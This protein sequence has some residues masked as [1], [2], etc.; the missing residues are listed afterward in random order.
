MILANQTPQ[1]FAVQKRQLPA[2]VI[3]QGLGICFFFW[4]SCYCSFAQN[5]QTQS[6]FTIPDSITSQLETFRSPTAQVDF[7]LKTIEQINGKDKRLAYALALKTQQLTEVNDLSLA[8]AQ[9]AYWEVATSYEKDVWNYKLKQPQEELAGLYEFFDEKNRLFWKARCLALLAT[10]QY[11]RGQYDDAQNSIAILMKL[12]ASFKDQ[13]PYAEILGD[14]YRIQANLFYG[15]KHTDSIAYYYQKAFDQYALDAG[16]NRSKMALININRAISATSQGKFDTSSNYYREAA[17]LANKDSNLQ[18]EIYLEWGINLAKQATKNKDLQKWT[19]SNA[20]LY[21]SD[22]LSPLFKPR[23]YYQLGANHQNVALNTPEIDSES[24]DTLINKALSYYIQALQASVD[25]ANQNI[26]SNV[27][28]SLVQLL[29]MGNIREDKKVMASINQGYLD[30]YESLQD[31][32]EVLRES[33]REKSE[34]EIQKVRQSRTRL[35]LIL[36]SV[37]IALAGISLFVYQQQRIKNLKQQFD[38]RMEA[39]RSQMNSHFIANTLNAIDS[40]IMEGR[41]EE[42]SKYIVGFSRLCRNILNS[43]KQ[44]YIKLSEEVQILEDYLTFEKLRLGNRLQVDWQIDETLDLKAHKVP[45]LILQPF[46]ENAIWHGILNKPNRLPG[47]LR[48]VLSSEG[49]E[50]LKCLIED[51]GIGRD[52]AKALRNQQAIEWQSWGMKITSERIQAIQQIK[53]A[54]VEIVDLFDE[55]GISKGTKVIILLPKHLKAV[56]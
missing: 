33:Q 53:D 35:A 12:A 15:T 54:K 6:A 4:I 22:T 52:K 27:S 26:L 50:N 44:A 14:G 32:E 23:V 45:S 41:K 37:L 39:L 7:L 2:L 34:M 38:N 46:V 25:N 43:S 30:I 18:G 47:T 3:Q 42:A 56:S 17:Q 31:I 24:Y 20:C 49:E 5:N 36:T 40:L 19:Q 55:K 13:K 8:A 21:R 48:I 11:A 10:I 16:R 28:T 9:A 51:D 29:E 1:G